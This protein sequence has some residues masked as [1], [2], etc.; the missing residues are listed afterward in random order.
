MAE[1]TAEIK[2]LVRNGLIVAGL[3]GSTNDY[4]ASYNSIFGDNGNL[5]YVTS[6]FGA[7]GDIATRVYARS[8]I[9]ELLDTTDN[10]FVINDDVL[11][12]FIRSIQGSNRVGFHVWLSGISASMDH[13]E[14]PVPV[15]PDA[16]FLSS[17]LSLIRAFN[18]SSSEHTLILKAILDFNDQFKITGFDSAQLLYISF[19]QLS[20]EQLPTTFSTLA[21]GDRTIKTKLVQVLSMI[22]NGDDIKSKEFLESLTGS[23]YGDLTF[24]QFV[25]QLVDSIPTTEYGPSLLLRRDDESGEE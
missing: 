12:T 17:I 21:R 3:S 4:M 18:G 2:T 14:Y 6:F 7:N 25:A 19:A 20:A 22:V 9:Q 13:K 1:A 24:N 5:S 16:Y 10:E 8:I 15:D 11:T 23:E